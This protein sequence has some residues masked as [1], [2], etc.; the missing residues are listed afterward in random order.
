MHQ[1]DHVSLG[2]ASIASPFTSHIGSVASCI[3]IIRQGRGSLVTTIEIFKI[4]ALNCLVNAFVLSVCTEFC[5]FFICDRQRAEY[6]SMQV[7]FLDGVKFGDQ[8]MTAAAL[9]R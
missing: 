9:L 2:D 7:L 6:H 4:I 5:F 1:Q 3:D 8:Q